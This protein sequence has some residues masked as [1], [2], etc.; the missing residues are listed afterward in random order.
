MATAYALNG[1]HELVSGC[2]DQRCRSLS[3]YAQAAMA[4][5]TS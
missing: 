3:R 5:M 2:L 1:L 4:L